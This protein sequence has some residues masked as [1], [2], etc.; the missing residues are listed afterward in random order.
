MV[1]DRIVA[2]TITDIAGVA[3]SMVRCSM[4]A[5]SNGKGRPGEAAFFVSYP[6]L[7]EYQVRG[8]VVPTIAG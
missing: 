3:G 8:E 4:E 6:L 7:S 2:A 5:S 1:A